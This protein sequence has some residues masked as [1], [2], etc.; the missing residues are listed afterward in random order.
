MV[1]GPEPEPGAVKVELFEPALALELLVKVYQHGAGALTAAG[2]PPTLQAMPIMHPR[3]TL[4][5]PS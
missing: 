2:I 3:T 1:R 5:H 4:V